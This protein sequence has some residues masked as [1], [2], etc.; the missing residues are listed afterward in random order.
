M[1]SVFRDTL[2]NSKVALLV[3][4]PKVLSRTLW[5]TQV[6]N[7]KVYF[8]CTLIAILPPFALC[9]FKLFQMG[10]QLPNPQKPTIGEF[11]PV[12]KEDQTK[13]Q[14]CFQTGSPVGEVRLGL[15]QPHGN[16]EL[17]PRWG[18]EVATQGSR[19]L[20]SGLWGGGAPSESW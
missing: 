10:P 3:S 19:S 7:W 9:S 18:L 4:E 14:N 17:Q 16:R 5:F 20:N 11:L 15:R 1:P 2:C 13:R 12:Y 8:I 6:L